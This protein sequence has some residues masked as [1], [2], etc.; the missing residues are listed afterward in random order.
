MSTGNWYP[1]NTPRV[2]H[3]GA[4]WKRLFHVVST[5]NTRDVFVGYRVGQ[6]KHDQATD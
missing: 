3:V 2:L 4:T 6:H 1:T 5:W